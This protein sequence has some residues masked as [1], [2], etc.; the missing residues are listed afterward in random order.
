VN[1][2]SKCS[3]DSCPDPAVTRFAQRELCLQHF[4]SH[5]YEDLE[6]FDCRTRGSQ[7]GHSEST[8]LSAFVD[9]C[10]R[11]ALEVSL[12]CGHLENLQRA[13]LLDILLWASELSPKTCAAARSGGNNSAH[14]ARRTTNL[15]RAL[16]LPD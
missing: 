11:C 9:E 10:S 6:R 15:V 5:C 12:N 8:R 3:V 14:V 13:R 16:C 1:G 7:G 2:T 4:L